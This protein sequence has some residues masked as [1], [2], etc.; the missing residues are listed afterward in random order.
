MKLRFPLADL[1]MRN[2]RLVLVTIG[3]LCALAIFFGTQFLLRHDRDAALRAENERGKLLS[4]ML[5]SH[6]TRT[7]N[8]VD[9]SLSAIGGMLQRAPGPAAR[10]AASAEFQ[11]QLDTMLSGS[12]Y[13]RS[14]SVLDSDGAVIASSTRA[15]VGLHFSNAQLGLEHVLDNTLQI[16]RP[17]FAHDL[18]D[19]DARTDDDAL[20]ER[21]VYA[22]PLARQ[23][24][25]GA[26]NLTLLTLL[27][28]PYLFPEARSAARL[29]RNYAVLF[30]YDGKALAATPDAP[31]A[32]GKRYARL[33][34]VD[35]LN[36]DIDFGAFRLEADA[37]AG[38]H[39]IS[40][41]ASPRFP[42]AAMVG[43]S[44][45]EV[46]AAWESSAR[47]LRFIGVIAAALGLIYTAM[48][49]RVMRSGERT[50]EELRI[51]KEAAESANAAKSS[52]L[53][54]MSH[55]IR[56]PM[57]GVLGMTALLRDTALDAR[58]QEYARTIEESAGALMAIINDILDFSKI[59][60]GRMELEPVPVEL[61]P[62]AESCVELLSG[63]AMTRGL[64]LIAHID[65]ALPAA[66]L[67]DGGR[68]RQILLN[69]LDN[70]IKFTETGAV[71]LRIALLARGDGVCRIGFEV[72]DSGIGI[73]P[74]ALSRL[75]Q[76]FTQADTSVTRRYGGTGLG[77][78][79]CKRLLDMMGSSISVDSALGRGSRFGFELR[80]RESAAPA[81][82]PVLPP[83]PVLVMTAQA[84]QAEML[85]DCLRHWGM[86]PLPASG[87]KQARELLAAA[88][89]TPPG[90][91]PL[92]LLDS[93]LP[94][95]AVLARSLAELRPDLRLLLLTRDRDA[96]ANMAG[97]GFH[98]LLP[99]PLR[100]QPL[101]D[102]LRFA[103]ERRQLRL[104]V[105]E[106]RRAE[107]PGPDAA[108]QRLILLAEDNP[109]NRKLAL[110]QLGRIGLAADIVEDGEA[111]L[112]ALR[113][114]DY[115]L[116]LMDCQMPVMDG[117]EATRRIREA[118]SERGSGRRLP[119]V[120][121]TANA[122]EGDR[123]RCLAAGMDDYLP[124]PVRSDALAAMLR[125]YLP[126]EQ[127]VPAVLD[128]ARLEELFGDDADMRRSL[129]CSFC[130]G[131]LP[132]LRQLDAALADDRRDEAD[133]IAH[134][135]LGSSANLGAREMEQ[136]ARTLR[137]ALR[138]ADANLARQC[139]AALEAAWHRFAAHL[140][141]EVR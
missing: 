25:I 125:R 81:P 32:V 74:Q 110:Y 39:R 27:H 115:A 71:S 11:S 12:S 126:A 5:E 19:L 138:D 54:T 131:T 101:L 96:G 45:R 85:V 56:T 21:G 130:E 42:L 90:Q 64:D 22:L 2:A 88:A 100:Q 40:Y 57:H 8:S 99:L 105:H 122:M 66:V 113:R 7:L 13:L 73:A 134:Q 124:K 9:N 23:I 31:Y 1:P 62:L 121:M 107:A 15:N 120:A 30:D 97:D 112:D 69:L 17:L 127:D 50:R 102:A 6:I 58:Q 116:V 67:V 84:R 46:L 63:K 61:L 35:A 51:A 139:H 24:R 41:Q 72:I 76:P 70:A 10:T 108:A 29:G 53:S 91:H 52:F 87:A 75:F 77:L 83:A 119:I 36:R 4:S 26:V 103:Q 92:A 104:P 78:S 48:L 16:G 128:P 137:Q 114:R 18:Y 86:Q 109:T 117:F 47:N 79:I 37:A 94:D 111:A 98:A 43:V 34:L 68:L 118:E 133:R 80:L 33:P 44:E 135:L 93:A 20:R 132:M 95:V 3:A 65:P 28:P 106:E 140:E 49:H 55:E 82:L 60:A 129:L 14:I 123:E 141:K 89:A 136:A 38:A 59:E